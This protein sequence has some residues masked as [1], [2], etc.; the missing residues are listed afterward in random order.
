MLFRALIQQVPSSHLLLASQSEV[1]RSNLAWCSNPL[2]VYYGWGVFFPDIVL[3][4]EIVL[5][6]YKVLSFCLLSNPSSR[7]SAV[8]VPF[9]S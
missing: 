2:S 9:Q 8:K 3:L 7:L 5:G 1:V 4:Q 6:L